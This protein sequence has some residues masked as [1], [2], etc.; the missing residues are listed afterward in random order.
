MKGI[1]THTILDLRRSSCATDSEQRRSLDSGNARL[2]GTRFLRVFP[3][4]SN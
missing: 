3:N 1:M 4:S 2:T